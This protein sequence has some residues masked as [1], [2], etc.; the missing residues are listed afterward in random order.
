[1]LLRVRFILTVKTEGFLLSAAAD[2]L[3]EEPRALYQHRQDPY[4]WTRRN[5]HGTTAPSAPL[6]FS[7]DAM[8]ASSANAFPRS[9][10]GENGLS[11]ASLAPSIVSRRDGSNER[12]GGPFG[13]LWTNWTS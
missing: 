8:E 1:M 13:R 9:R 10:L 7:M 11:S 5:Y 3:T 6:R 4:S 12:C 2:E